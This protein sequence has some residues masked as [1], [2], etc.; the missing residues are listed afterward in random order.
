MCGSLTTGAMARSY[1]GGP[2]EAAAVQLVARLALSLLVISLLV[3]RSP[4]LSR[5]TR[6]AQCSGRRPR[7]R[8]LPPSGPATG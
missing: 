7:P 6:L 5:A 3:F 2:S 4:P 1:R 8:N